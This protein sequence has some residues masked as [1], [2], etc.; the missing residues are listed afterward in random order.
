MG[1]VLNV[2]GV[3]SFDLFFSIFV[4]IVIALVPVML[5]VCVLTTKFFR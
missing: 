1:S 5:A 4:Y 3:A 2:T